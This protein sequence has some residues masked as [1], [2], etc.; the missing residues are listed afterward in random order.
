MRGRTRPYTAAGVRR[1]KCAR[2][3]CPNR[4]TQQWRVCSAS[5][6]TPV[7]AACDY[8]INRLVLGFMG[9]PGAGAKLAAYRDRHAAALAEAA[10]PKSRPRQR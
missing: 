8:E 5:V 4:A 1:L 3:G 9:D 7:C 2:A 10:P 6:W